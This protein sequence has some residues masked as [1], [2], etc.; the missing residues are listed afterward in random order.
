[1]VARVREGSQPVR[2]RA[3]RRTGGTAGRSWRG[4]RPSGYGLPGVASRAAPGPARAAS[5]TP[6]RYPASAT[7]VAGVW[8][9][10]SAVRARLRITH[11]SLMA[12]RGKGAGAAGGVQPGAA[13]QRRG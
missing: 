3:L 4:V 8:R 2:A 12:T 7:T 10:A 11:G 1:M 13:Y 9:E 5:R 6:A